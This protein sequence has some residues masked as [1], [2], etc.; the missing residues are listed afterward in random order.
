MC[1]L[2]FTEKTLMFTRWVYIARIIIFQKTTKIVNS[3][4]IIIFDENRKC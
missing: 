1:V 4:K 3:T 2:K